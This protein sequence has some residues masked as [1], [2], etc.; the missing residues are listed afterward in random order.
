MMHM[1]KRRLGSVVLIV[2]VQ[3]T[4][5]AFP[6]EAAPAEAA[7]Q[8]PVEQAEP[9]ALD[10]ITTF[11]TQFL[12]GIKPCEKNQPAS[13]KLFNNCQDDAVLNQISTTP[14]K[15]QL[16]EQMIVDDLV[17]PNGNILR[18]DIQRKA[19][20]PKRQNTSEN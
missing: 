4:G 3:A 6:E 8:L 2:A 14:Q 11:E 16:R 17:A 13:G 12:P 9:P 7:A 20:L 15:D 1:W 5:S 18:I 19:V 10:T